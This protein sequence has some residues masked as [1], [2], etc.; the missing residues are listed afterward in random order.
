MTDRDDPLSDLAATVSERSSEH[1]TDSG[2]K[3]DG[4]VDADSSA[5]FDDLFAREDVSGIDG[6]RLWRRLEEGV[7]GAA[8]DSGRDVRVVDKHAYCHQCDHFD[9]PPAVGCG[10]EEADILGMPSVE[11]FRI[12]DCPIV[13]ENERLERG[14]DVSSR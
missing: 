13:R 1:D 10:H 7:S 14:G 5:E 11:T 4:D 8:S 9:Q 3:F 2:A 12:V 6:D